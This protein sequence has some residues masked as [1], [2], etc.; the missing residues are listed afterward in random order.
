MCINN[1]LEMGTQHCHII[2]FKDD[3]AKFSAISC[4]VYVATQ[5][6]TFIDE[7]T[8]TNCIVPKA[9]LCYF[10]C[11][12]TVIVLLKCDHPPQSDS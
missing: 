2:N 12:L 9:L 11:L 1:Y 3:T 5:G 8:G 10:G 4:L 6:C 7:N